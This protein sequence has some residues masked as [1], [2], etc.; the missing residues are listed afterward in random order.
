MLIVDIKYII[1]S[2]LIEFKA[3]IPVDCIANIN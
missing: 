3:A 2:K 1:Q